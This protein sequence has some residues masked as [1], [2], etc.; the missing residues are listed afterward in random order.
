MKPKLC[1]VCG[2]E[3]CDE[4]SS[5]FNACEDCLDNVRRDPGGFIEQSLS[6]LP[7]TPPPASQLVVSARHYTTTNEESQ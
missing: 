1:C 6:D 2:E 3:I 7:E 5:A 4:E